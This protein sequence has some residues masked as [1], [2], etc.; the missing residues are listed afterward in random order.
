[1]FLNL[2]LKLRIII[3]I[4]I[5][6]LPLLADIFRW[7][8]STIGVMIQRVQI[9]PRLQKDYYELQSQFDELKDSFFRLAMKG[10]KVYEIISA[11]NQRG[12][13]FIA[14]RTKEGDSLSHGQRIIIIDKSDQTYMGQFEV[15]EDFPGGYY[16]RGMKDIDPVWL[17][18]IH[19]YGESKMMP[20]VVGIS[21][22]IGGEN[23]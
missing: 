23:E 4:G 8:F 7:G 22:P 2:S 15:V 12:S 5:A 16:A 10:T 6:T 14:L 21:I 11:K 3:G 13:L 9:Y 20:N 18:Y 17:G 1:M 19:E